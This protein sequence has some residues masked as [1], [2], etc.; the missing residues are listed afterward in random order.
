MPITER[1]LAPLEYVTCELLCLTV[2]FLLGEASGQ[3]IH[4][5]KCRWMPIPDRLA[6]RVN[7]AT[8]Q[9]L[10]ALMTTVGLKSRGQV[11]HDPERLW[12]VGSPALGRQ[13]NSCRQHLPGLAAPLQA[14]EQLP[15]TV[16]RLR[17][18]RVL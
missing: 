15:E 11:V 7:D 18:Q 5:N 4:R 13:L 17:P 12:I 14:I 2:L 1:N 16:Q 3:V 9:E 6:P 10:G 8:L